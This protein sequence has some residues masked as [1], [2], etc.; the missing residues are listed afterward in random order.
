MDATNLKVAIMIQCHKQSG[1]IER[2]LQ[3]L[4]HPDVDLYIHVD[5]KSPM[6]PQIHSERVHYVPDDQRVNVAWGDYSQCLATLRMMECVFSSG[7]DYDFV[8]LISGQDYPLRR[9]DDICRFLAQ[10]KN[11]T[12]IDM[13]SADGQDFGRFVKR[14][15]LY[16]FRFMLGKSITSR[17]CRNLCYYLTGGR[18]RTFSIFRRKSPFSAYYFG[19]QWWCMP[20]HVAKEVF[21]LASDKTISN[22]FRHSTCPDESMFHTL[23]MHTKAVKTVVIRKKLAYI[24]WSNLE[25]SP[26]VLTVEDM[27]RLIEASRTCLIGRKFD[28]DIDSMVLDMLDK[29]MMN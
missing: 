6:Q 26:R 13:V 23:L 12:F 25:N 5:K 4:R 8:W 22:F 24:D 9:I 29:K 15:E 11:E 27:P 18:G 14:N 2:L 1:Q 28:V 21:E 16:H 17:V 10:H 3:A 19:S 20:G 7:R